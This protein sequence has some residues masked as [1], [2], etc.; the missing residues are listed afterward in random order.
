[1]YDYR[2]KREREREIRDVGKQ[3]VIAERGRGVEMKPQKKKRA[4]PLYTVS[5]FPAP[6]RITNQHIF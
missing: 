2:T 1:M 6:S 4:L 3:G 5:D